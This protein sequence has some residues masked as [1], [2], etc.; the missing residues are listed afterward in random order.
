MTKIGGGVENPGGS[1]SSRGVCGGGAA[2]A[3][4]RQ[5]M[6]AEAT[7][8]R[9]VGGVGDS[10]LLRWNLERLGARRPPTHRSRNSPIPGKSVSANPGP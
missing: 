10:W 8:G 4:K 3:A 9:L 2:A 1:A 6:F 5:G 7:A